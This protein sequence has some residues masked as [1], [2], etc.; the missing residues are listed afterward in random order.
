MSDYTTKVTRVNDIYFCRVDY[1]GKPVVQSKVSSREDIGPA[2]RDL[3]RTL[4]K[5]NGGEPFTSA[6]R[7][8]KDRKGNKSGI[9]KHEWL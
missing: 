9:F 1:K 4:D 5:G 3:L 7:D 8:R 2:F 6:A